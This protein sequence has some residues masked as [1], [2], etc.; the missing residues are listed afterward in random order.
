MKLRGVVESWNMRSCLL[1]FDINF[2]KAEVFA[3]RFEKCRLLTIVLRQ[4]V[5]KLDDYGCPKNQDLARQGK[6]D[7]S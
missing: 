7:R 2:I 6:T 4:N 1:S 5:E 3:K